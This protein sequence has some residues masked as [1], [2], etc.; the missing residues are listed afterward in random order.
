MIGGI[1]HAHQRAKPETMLIKL[2]ASIAGCSKRINV[3]DRIRPPD[4]EL[5]QIEQSRAAS[6]IF[7]TG[8]ARGIRRAVRRSHLH[9]FRRS[10]RTLIGKSAHGYCV[11]AVFMT[12][13]ACFTASTM[14]G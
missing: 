12:D 7:D 8:N 4:I 9:G 2:N 5:H 13:R 3:D 10:L 1:S 6:E 14:F 11:L